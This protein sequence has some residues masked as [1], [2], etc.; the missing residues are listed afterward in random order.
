MPPRTCLLPLAIAALGGLL[1]AQIRPPLPG[2]PM[3]PP[4]VDHPGLAGQPLFQPPRHADA[5]PAPPVVKPPV[6]ASVDPDTAGPKCSGKD[7]GD[8]VAKVLALPWCTNLDEALAQ[9]AAQR[10]PVLWLQALGDL[11]G[12]AC[13]ALQSLRGITLANET[14]LAKLR[15]RFVLGRADLE[16]APH[17]GVSNG[18]RPDQTALGATNGAG[19]RNLQL[20]VLAADGTV[21]HAVPGFWHPLDLLPELELARHLHDLHGSPDHTA[22]Q[23]LAMARTLHRGFLRE[24]GSGTLGRSA[25][26]AEDEAAEQEQPVRD[27]FARDDKGLVVRGAGGLPKLVPLVQLVHERMLARGF[28]P[29][30]AFDWESFVDYGTPRHDPNAAIE[31]GRTFPKAIAN[32]QRRERDAARERG[33]GG[34]RR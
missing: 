26:R 18:Y 12:D 19:G 3:T 31:T 22:A 20:V 1:A 28:V 6:P 15:E 14:V 2:L 13:S 10:K 30:A 11:G 25:W 7:L 5:P 17:V 34:R 21:V 27:S 24:L 4:P 32:Q 8:A 23:K 29:C 16:A 9:A 33:K